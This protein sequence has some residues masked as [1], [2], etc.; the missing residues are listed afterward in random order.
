MQC[1][2]L[3]PGLKDP[4]KI[5]R[6]R[7]AKMLFCAG[8]PSGLT[9]MNVHT[10]PDGVG[11]NE[12]RVLSDILTVLLQEILSEASEQKERSLEMKGG[13]STSFVALTAR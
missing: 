1:L 2:W 10:H 3:S 9:V 8:D 5:F 13:R 4:Q 7:L 12:S 11:E 6:N